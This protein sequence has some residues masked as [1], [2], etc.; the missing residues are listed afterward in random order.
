MFTTTDIVMARDHAGTLS[1]EVTEIED[2]GSSLVFYLED[3]DSNLIC[4][5]QPKVDAPGRH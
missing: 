4:I 2:I 3:L 5:R 1:S